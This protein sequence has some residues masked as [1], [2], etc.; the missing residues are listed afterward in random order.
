MSLK[1]IPK[2]KKIAK[3]LG[4]SKVKVWVD[5]ERWILI[6]A[7]SWDVAGN[8]LKTVVI[9]DFKKVQNIWTYHTIHVLNHKTKHENR[10]YFKR[11][12]VQRRF[13]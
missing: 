6:K 13:K 11:C 10:V 2:D 8:F 3:E 7:E 1:G 12:G 5:A 4:Q 9:K